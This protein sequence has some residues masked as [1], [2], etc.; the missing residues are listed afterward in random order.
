MVLLQLILNGCFTT[1]PWD[2]LFY[3]GGTLTT[4]FSL[5]TIDFSND[6]YKGVIRLSTSHT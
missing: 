6:V 4:L 3:P 2:W 5:Y 1:E